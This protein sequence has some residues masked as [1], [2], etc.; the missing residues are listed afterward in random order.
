MIKL[1]LIVI[2]IDFV[3]ECRYNCKYMKYMKTPLLVF[4]I[5]EV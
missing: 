5:F 1:Y 3:L 2:E 4:L